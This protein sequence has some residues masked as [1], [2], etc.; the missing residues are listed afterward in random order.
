[1]SLM[2][3]FNLQVYAHA[4]CD[5]FLSFL[6]HFPVVV[7]RHIEA[8]SFAMVPIKPWA[9]ESPYCSFPFSCKRYSFKTALKGT[10]GS[11][12]WEREEGLA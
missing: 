7:L 5:M 10:M 11:L 6:G 3:V 12:T 9:L 2:A 1:M 4:Y 8:F